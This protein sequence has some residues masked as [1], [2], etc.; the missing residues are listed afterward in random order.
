MKCPRCG[1]ENRDIDRFCKCCGANLLEYNPNESNGMNRERIGIPQKPQSKPVRI[2]FAVLHVLFYISLYYMVNAFVQSMYGSAFLLS[3]G[4]TEMDETAREMVLAKLSENLVQIMLVVN[5][6]TLLIVGLLQTL[7]KRSVTREIKLE[8]INFMRLPTFAILG[9]ALNVFTTCTI[10]LLPISN[11]LLESLN[12]QYAS[13]F[14]EQSLFMQILS[15]AIVT[16]IVEEVI[17]RGLVITRLE[18]GFGKITAVVISAIIFG[19]FHSTPIAIAYATVLGLVFGMMYIVYDSIIPSIVC[20]VFFNLASYVISG[21]RLPIEIM[22][23]LSAV[24]IVYFGY[25]AFIRRPTF[26]DILAD[27]ACKIKG[28][29]A[30]ERAIFDE[31]RSLTKMEEVTHEDIEKLSNEFD[32]IIEKR[33]N[34]RTKNKK[35]N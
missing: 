31:V 20:H 18:R 6:V 25:R 26:S 19:L 29:N 10:N 23:V 11:E 3:R 16:G 24:L 2:L 14:E 22:Y 30:E 28:K 15:V 32:R 12:S 5:L 4:I 33:K 34:N 8:R 27:R 9:F 1:T 7:R 21:I 17:F 35:D 13:L